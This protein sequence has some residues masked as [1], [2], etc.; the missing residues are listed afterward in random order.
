MKRIC[1][2]KNILFIVLLPLFLITFD[3]MDS[4]KSVHTFQMVASAH[5]NTADSGNQETIQKRNSHEE[6]YAQIGDMS[7]IRPWIMII[8]FGFPFLI[9]VLLVTILLTRKKPQK[10]GFVDLKQSNAEM[11]KEVRMKPSIIEP[12]G[13]IEDVKRKPVNPEVLNVEKLKEKGRF[14]SGYHFVCEE[15]ANKGDKFIITKYVTTIGRRS[16]DGRVNDIEFST[17]DKKISRSQAL[18]VFH[19]NNSRFYLINESLT[20]ISVNG[21]IV[22]QAYPIF[23]GDEINLGSDEVKLKLVKHNK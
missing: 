3:F 12:Q 23:E 13:A 11:P 22:E 16:S 14:N 6:Q 10:E 2:I 5:E 19:P 18:L 9:L 17:S 20:P 21:N 1:L 7:E 8:I 15:G 4:S